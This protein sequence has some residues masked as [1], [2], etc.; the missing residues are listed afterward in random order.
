M[1]DPRQRNTD[2]A[3]KP[4]SRYG[5]DH[6]YIRT[7]NTFKIGRHLPEDAHCSL[8]LLVR[9]Q[10]RLLRDLVHLELC[11]DLLSFVKHLDFICSGAAWQTHTQVSLHGGSASW[12]FLKAD[13]HVVYSRW[14]FRVL[15]VHVLIVLPAASLFLLGTIT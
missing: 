6:R 1:H 3:T 14:D 11:N 13:A 10:A 5:H 2:F 7:S 8:L 15:H 12:R 9:G 4:A